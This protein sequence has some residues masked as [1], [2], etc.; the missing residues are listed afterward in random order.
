MYPSCG[1]GHEVAVPVLLNGGVIK[2]PCHM[3]VGM[4][5]GG[6][7]GGYCW[8]LLLHGTVECTV[9][10]H[11]GMALLNGTVEMVLLNALLHGTVACTVGWYCWMVLFDLCADFCSETSARAPISELQF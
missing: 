3:R 11:C 2:I 8:M 10:W 7:C 6:Y 9:E 1:G 4:Y 5:C